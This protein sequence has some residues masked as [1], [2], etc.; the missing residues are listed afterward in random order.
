MFTRLTAHRHRLTNIGRPIGLPLSKTTHLS[1]PALRPVLTAAAQQTRMPSFQTHQ[2]QPR[3]DIVFAKQEFSEED[4]ADHSWRQHNHIWTEEEVEERI[5]QADKKYKPETLPD[6]AMY[7]LMRTMYHGFNLVT[8]YDATNPSAKSIEWRLIVLESF[9]GVPGFL[10]AMFRHFYSL[11]NL[12]RDHG[13]IYTLLEEAENERMHLLVCLKMFEKGWFTRT[14]VMAAQFGM[15]PFLSLVYAI[16]PQSMH[17]FVGY[18]EE[19]AVETYANVVEKVQEPGTNLNEAWADLPA[20]G[21]AQVYWDLNPDSK[22]VDVLRRMLADEAHHRDVNHTFACLPAGSQN[23][24]LHEHAH[25]FDKAAVRRSEK[26]L[27]QA[28]ENL[29]QEQLGEFPS[30]IDQARG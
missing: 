1:L 15:T 22:W 8:G 11:R 21:I 23:P 6:H 9:A 19:T 28:L 17:R 29:N 13:M 4:M 26:I 14:L 20:P 18:L 27:K 25:D 16:H 24:F 2:T 30:A 10:A 5:Q 7:T 12:Q 3:R